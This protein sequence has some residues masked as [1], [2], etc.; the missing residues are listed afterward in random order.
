VDHHRPDAGASEDA[1]EI[2]IESLAGVSEYLTGADQIT[3]RNHP[4]PRSSG[5]EDDSPVNSPSTRDV[6]DGIAVVRDRCAS[7]NPD[8]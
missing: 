6:N 3:D 7:S 5:L 4:L 2:C 8:T 1:E